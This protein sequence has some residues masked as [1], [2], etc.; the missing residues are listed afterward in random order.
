[1]FLLPFFG[2]QLLEQR[3]IA[4][5]FLPHASSIVTIEREEGKHGF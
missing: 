2:P 4:N 1:M 3:A 5:A